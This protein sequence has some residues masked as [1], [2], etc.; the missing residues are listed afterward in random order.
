MNTMKTIEGE[1]FKWMESTMRNE[2]RSADEMD[3]P[4]KWLIDAR[5]AGL[6]SNWSNRPATKPISKVIDKIDI[7]QGCVI[8]SE[9]EQMVEFASGETKNKESAE[10]LEMDEIERV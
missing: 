8:H 4:F 1:E 2:R 9:R 7:L 10:K 5:T 6:Q 3:K